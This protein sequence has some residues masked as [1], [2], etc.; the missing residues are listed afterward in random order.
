M[1]ESILGGLPVEETNPSPL[2]PLEVS[3]PTRTTFS[4]GCEVRE[5]A[6]LEPVNSLNDGGQNPGHLQ[7]R[8]D[9]KTT[10]TVSRAK[11][12]QTAV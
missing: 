10:N 9:L 12:R 7:A 6:I 4:V 2:G 11:I 1:C 5:A 3:W 8:I